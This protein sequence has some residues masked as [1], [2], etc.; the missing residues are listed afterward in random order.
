M[1][2]LDRT[3]DADREWLVNQI[4]H[5]L[6][7]PLFAASVQTE[8]LLLRIDDPDAVRTTGGKLHRQLQRL[9]RTIDEMLLLG[10]PYRATPEAVAVADLFTALIQR[11][12][13]DD[14]RGPARLTTEVMPPELE[15]WWDRAAVTLI[16]ERFID[17]AVQHTPA[18][19]EIRLSA[20]AV[21]DDEVA[22]STIDRG[23][24]IPP[25][26][27]EQALLPFFPQHSG[28]PGLGLAV[29]DKLARVIG[30]RIEIESVPGEGTTARCVL[31]IRSVD[32][33][34][35]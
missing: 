30:G 23:E 14:R 2:D 16:L 22:L 12:E 4:A 28:R 13:C 25:D 17:N 8:S 21:N 15:G 10:R 6:R 33:D 26:I 11:Y 35:T 24:G 5:A 27:L 18:P 20:E 7:N 32:H 29:A 31:P 1:A 34:Q 9:S 3:P 19:H